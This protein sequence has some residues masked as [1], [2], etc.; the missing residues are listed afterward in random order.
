[1]T[2]VEEWEKGAGDDPVVYI[3]I[4][5]LYQNHQQYKDAARCFQR[6]LD[7]SPSYDVTTGL[8]DAYRAAGKEEL[9]KPTL[10]RYLE[11][12]DLGLAHAQIHKVRGNGPVGG[13]RAICS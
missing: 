2:Q 7:I 4:G 9:W 3:L 5:G 1:M 6:S 11:V 8:A 10:E 12:E 13:I